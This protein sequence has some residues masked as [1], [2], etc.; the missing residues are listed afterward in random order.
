MNSLKEY[1]KQN[2]AYFTD[3]FDKSALSNIASKIESDP[4]IKEAFYIGMLMSSNIREN[5]PS[6]FMD[7]I[8]NA[9]RENI[10]DREWKS[11]N[12]NFLILLDAKSIPYSYKQNI[13]KYHELLLILE[14]FYPEKLYPQVYINFNKFNK[15][16]VDNIEELIN[17]N[18][19]FHLIFKHISSCFENSNLFNE[20]LKVN[21]NMLQIKLNEYQNLTGITKQLPNVIYKNKY[22]GS[23]FIS[24]DM[25]QSNSMILFI[26]FG[27]MLF[28]ECGKT[29]SEM[30]CGLEK[31]YSDW[32]QLLENFK[33]SDF[34]YSQKSS[35]IKKV[36][37]DEIFDSMF[38]LFSTSKKIRV[39]LLGLIFKAKNKNYPPILK[40]IEIVSELIMQQIAYFIQPLL[41]L[42][43][44]NIICLSHDEIII[45]NV[46]YGDLIK[47]FDDTNF[48]NN[49]KLMIKHLRIEE[50]I[51]NA[52]KQPKTGTYYIKHDTINNTKT[53]KLLKPDDRLHV[54]V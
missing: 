35:E 48:D 42:Q 10:F 47:Y 36:V 51:L 8:S 13:K 33:W 28:N 32:S 4:N 39:L 1:L 3:A 5:G 21:R 9:V 31:I 14:K 29:I 30:N 40:L 24:I 22:D 43:S 6:D 20:I 19:Q 50:F 27:N 44:G 45:E 18:H 54:F 23:K 49:I 38:D 25:I 41:K 12:E 46:N 15:L 2:T 16:N 53:Y 11:F 17:F 52:Y 37:N 34:V 26:Y 7:N